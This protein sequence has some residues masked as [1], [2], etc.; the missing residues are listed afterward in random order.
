MFLL[1]A[2][3]CLDLA[4]PRYADLTILNVA[5]ISMVAVE[6]SLIPFFIPFL[7]KKM[8]CLHS[9]FEIKVS[10]HVHPKWKTIGLPVL[11]GFVLG[12]ALVLYYLS[13]NG[14]SLQASYN[15]FLIF[16]CPQP[17][18]VL[19]LSGASHETLVFLPSL[20]FSRVQNLISSTLLSV[21]ET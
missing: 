12:A 19:G 18:I 2:M 21:L 7:W 5:G 16:T 14:A 8:S 1:F 9:S 17:L 4:L 13:L 3:N 6:I 10:R 11:G 20:S 15:V